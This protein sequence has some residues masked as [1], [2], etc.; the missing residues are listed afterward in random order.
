MRSKAVVESVF[1][2]AG[3]A[4]NGRNPWDLQ[5]HD[6]RFYNR[7]LAERSLGLGESYM[8]GWWDSE[9]VDE[10]IHR[11]LR[12]GADQE[13][14]NSPRM[15]LAWLQAVLVNRQ[16]KRRS[17]VVA[18]QHYDI[19]NDVFLSFLDDYNQYSCAYFRNTNDLDAAQTN[20][21][22]LICRKLNLKPG[23]KVLDIGFGWGGLSRYMA[24]KYQCQVTGVNISSQ[25]MKY[26]TDLC[27]DLPVRLESRD[28]REIDG[29]FDKIVSVGMFEHVGYKNYRCFMEVVHRILKQDGVFL[30][31]T[32]GGNQSQV[33]L[34]PW[35]TKYIFPNSM[36]P[37]ISQIGKAIEGLLVMEDWHN[38]GPHY[39]R[40][41]MAWH[42]R[43][44]NAWPKLKG[45]YGERFKRM[46][47]YYLLSCAGAFRSR[48]IQLWQIVMTKGAARQPECRLA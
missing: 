45:Q 33:R 11:L 39:D 7:V 14:R 44:Q 12:A 36:L 32:I 46:W 10:L 29:Q 24:E 27:R 25:Q 21:L 6:K 30:L 35:L 2:S 1:A 23:D 38:L 31:Q 16:S 42:Q 13:N 37:S 48:S 22:D 47:D 5:I 4:V 26:A 20:K 19:G 40:T 17:L 3:I 8:D 43:F 18:E 28:Y 41:L 34:E 9:R 15:W